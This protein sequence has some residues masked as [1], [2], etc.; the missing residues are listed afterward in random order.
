MSP[1]SLTKAALVAALLVII[2]VISWEVYLRSTGFE[3]GFDDGGPIW[4]Y[5]RDKIYQPIDKATVFIGSSRIKF[6][7][8]IET[9]E[10]LTGD[11]P[12]Q[13]ACVGSTPRPLLADLA[14]DP[15]FKGKVIV[16]VTEG[17]FFS[18]SPQNFR[19]PN[20]AIEY[21]NKITPT[22]RAGFFLNKPLESTFVFLDKEHYSINAMLD[23]LEIPSRPGVR[24]SPIFPRDFGY[25]HFNRQE[26][27]GRF[28]LTDTAQQ[29]KQQ[30]IWALFGR[31][32]R[33]PPISGPPLDSI[34][35]TVKMDVDKI[36]ARGGKVLF[37]RTPSS[38]PYLEGEEKGFPREKYWDRLLAET[39]CQG[40]HFK[41]FPQIE[42]YACPEFSHLSPADAIDFTKHFIE[43]LKTDYG[44]TF[45]NSNNL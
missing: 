19:R 1:S 24:M 40:I 29:H 42:H 17:L 22:Q 14:D 6:D 26:Y 16:D 5:H 44:W 12:I 10:K 8:D 3:L 35:Q 9:W 41:D 45:A 21:H 25:V 4:S 27:M 30:Q 38:G 37:V 28:F 43:I 2:A 13:L 7:L 36:K 18:M 11:H 39:G 31:I 20:E 33:N 34:I 23:A 32:N 15:K